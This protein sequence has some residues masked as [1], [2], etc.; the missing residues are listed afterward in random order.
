MVQTI[1]MLNHC[2]CHRVQHVCNRHAPLTL[3][4]HFRLVDGQPSHACLG[5]PDDS[6]VS[7]VV[8]VVSRLPP[9]GYYHG[10]QCIALSNKVG[11]VLVVEVVAV[12]SQVLVNL[13]YNHVLMWSSR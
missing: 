10:T 9:E 5:G 2:W 13:F 6:T 11:V 8:A 12:K 4:C 7:P 1:F 3:L